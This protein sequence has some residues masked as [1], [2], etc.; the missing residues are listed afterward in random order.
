VPLRTSLSSTLI[1]GLRAIMQA[2]FANHHRC[3]RPRL[4]AALLMLAFAGCGGAVS[5][6]P[7]RNADALGPESPPE[8]CLRDAHCVVKN[9]GNCCGYYPACVH[10]DQPVDP[11]G[12][13]RRCAEQGLSSICGYPEI[14]ACACVDG[15]CR[16]ADEPR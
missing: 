10:V 3:R 12:V 9:V 7:A 14:S 2:P 11:E 8:R 4:L 5:P 13:V 16:A 1:I 6:A 15:E